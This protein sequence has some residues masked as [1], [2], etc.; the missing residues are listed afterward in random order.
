MAVTLYH[1]PNCSNSRKALGL[2]RERG[3]RPVVV[4]YLTPPWTAMP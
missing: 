2:I 3:V 1:N 4:E